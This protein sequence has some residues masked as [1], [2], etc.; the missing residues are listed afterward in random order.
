ML[1]LVNEIH[2]GVSSAAP[3]IVKPAPAR[4]IPAPIQPNLAVLVMYTSETEDTAF[5]REVSH[6]TKSTVFL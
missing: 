2:T 1:R 6:V 5:G 4:N 3:T